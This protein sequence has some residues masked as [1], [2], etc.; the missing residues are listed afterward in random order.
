MMQTFQ[1]YQTAI[2]KQMSTFTINSF[3]NMNV[4]RYAVGVGSS[5][6]TNNLIFITGDP[7]N[8]FSI[9]DFDSLKNILYTLKS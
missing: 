5:I 6:K 3:D 1:I 7:N 8:V 2:T 4:I 9:D